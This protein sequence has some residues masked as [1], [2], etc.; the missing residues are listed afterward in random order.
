MLYELFQVIRVQEVIK[1]GEFFV[2]PLQGYRLSVLSRRRLCQGLDFG[3][4]HVLTNADERRMM[5]TPGYTGVV[6]R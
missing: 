2:E 1:G 4:R 3:R 6:D 5:M